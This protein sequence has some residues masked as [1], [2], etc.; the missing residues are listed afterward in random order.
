[1][2]HPSS[3]IYSPFRRLA[4]ALICLCLA[5]FFAQPRRTIWILLAHC[6]PV[7]QILRAVDHQHQRSNLGPVDCH[8]GED[9]GGVG[10]CIRHLGRHSQSR[11]C[12]ED[13][14]SSPVRSIQ[15]QEEVGARGAA[16]AERLLPD[17]ARIV[18]RR[19]RIY[20]AW[21][22]LCSVKNVEDSSIKQNPVCRPVSMAEGRVQVQ[23]L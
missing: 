2:H 22:G 8:V 4:T 16:V 1:M 17:S 19:M 7:R 15:Y 18:V 13:V 10:A 23:E 6:L 12:L 20:E 9:A 3:W 21:I 11:K 14:Y 5:G